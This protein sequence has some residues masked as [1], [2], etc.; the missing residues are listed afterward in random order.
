MKKAILASVAALVAGTGIAFGQAP[1]NA[2]TD[3][4]TI[5]ASGSPMYDPNVV[6]AWGRGPLYLQ[7]GPEG[8]Y[9]PDAPGYMCGRCGTGENCGQCR[10][11]GGRGCEECGP[12]WPQFHKAAG[13]PDCFFFDVEAIY[14]YARSMKISAPMITSGPIGSAARIGED[15]TTV[16]FGGDN[17]RYGPIPSL[18]LNMG[19]WD[20]TRCWGWNASAFIT[21][22]HA[23]VDRFDA[24]ITGRTVLAR[25]IVNVLTGVPDSIIVAN[26][27]AFG[28]SALGYANLQSGGAEL[29]LMRNW[30]YYDRFKLTG[31]A[32]FRWYNLNE[33]VRVDTTA[34]VPG[35]DPNDPSI[36]TISDR[37][38]TRNNFYGGQ[39]GATVEVRRGRWF[40]EATGKVAAGFTHEQLKQSGFT[41]FSG[42]ALPGEQIARDPTTT[43]TIPYGAYVLESNS[44][45]FTDKEFAW[46]PEFNLKIG[47]QWTQRFSTFFGYDALYISKVVR[48]GEQVNP[49]INP[50]LLPI[51][52]VF[53]P[54]FPFGPPEPSLIFKKSDFFMQGFTF[55]AMYRY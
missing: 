53:N 22:Q 21:E 49:N 2:P 48:A 35:A 38:L 54:Q 12:K 28:G 55:G 5:S 6:Q 46:M 44:G 30:A 14:F 24:P 4:S 17:V 39:A 31:L 40:T 42:P 23:E 25:P 13:G 52:D 36:R 45:T 3:P 41:Q 43:T 18:R 47:Y 50:T 37:F 1:P 33:E 29:N 20:E 9:P 16:L 11:C 27:P 34:V 19:I 15:G 8:G 26:P 7:G 10:H 51:S 32:G